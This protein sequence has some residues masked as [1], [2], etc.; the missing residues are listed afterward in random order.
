MLNE[1][2]IFGVSAAEFVDQAP[3]SGDTALDRGQAK[4]AV[5]VGNLGQRSAEHIVVEPCGG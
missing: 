5:E 4:L 2:E 1:R 3:V